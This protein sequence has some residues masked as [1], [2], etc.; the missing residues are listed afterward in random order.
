[1]RVTSSFH[2]VIV[3][4][5]AMLTAFCALY[6]A[7]KPLIVKDGKPNAEIIISGQPTRT[8]KLAAEE[9]QAGI[10]KMTGARLDVT[11]APGEKY[12]VKIYV[13]RSVFTDKQGIDDNG[14]D[15]GAFRVKSGNSWLALVG[16]D[17]DFVP[18]EPWTKAGAPSDPDKIRMMAEWDRRTGSFYGN[19][20]GSLGRRYNGALEM[21][22]DDECGSLNA[23]YAFLGR[24]G[25]RW[26]MAGELGEIMP[27]LSDIPLPAVDE[28][29]RPAFGLRCIF[30][31][32][33]TVFSLKRDDMLWRLRLGLNASSR[34]LGPASYHAHGLNNVLLR[35]EMRAAHPEYYAMLAGGARRTNTNHACLSS[36]GLA[37]EA[38]R[39]AR[40]AF[41]VY[42]VP[43]VSLMPEDGFTFCKCDLCK[44]KEMPEHGR[45]GEHS[46]YVWG[47]VDRVAR[48]VAKTH[49]DRTISCAAY[50]T[51]VLPPRNIQKL[52][53][54]VQVCIVHGRGWLFPDASGYNPVE[55][56]RAWQAKTDRP[57][58]GYEHYPLTHRGHEIP[59]YF[60]RA[61]AAGLRAHAGSSHGEFVEIGWGPADVRGHGLHSPEFAHLKVYVTARLYWDPDLNLDALLEE[62]YRLFYGPAA[63]EMKR[64]IEYAEANWP[65]MKK[66]AKRIEK[67]QELFAAARKKAEP[68]SVYDRR[69][70]PLAEFL[71]PMEALRERLSRGREGTPAGKGLARPGAQIKVDGRLDEAAWKDAPVIKLRE[72]RSGKDPAVPTEFRVIWD[73][74]E[75]SGLLC[76]GIRCSE[77]DMAGLKITGVRDGDDAMWHGD[78]VE[79]M[80]ETQCHSYY[81]LTVDPLGRVYDIDFEGGRNFEW[82]AK[83]RV[84]TFRGPDF[85]SAEICLPV[86]GEEKPGDPLHELAGWKPTSKEPWHI[87]VC[88]GRVRGDK[89]EQSAWSPVGEKGGWHNWLKFGKFSVE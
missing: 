38:A 25:A 3:A 57:L 73:G 32:S 51:Y 17:D 59:Y 63:A 41:D 27:E 29:V 9:L 2:V 70:A 88:R 24:L 62:H 86:T 79:L 89:Q 18:R 30:P 43:S 4:V 40:A 76:F 84:A 19:P 71:A 37:Q 77:P 55:L 22:A 80:L 15:D 74:K 85:W 16:R 78:T 46:D 36:E 8:Q 58:M 26:Y 21:W 69:I 87:N 11:N 33:D 44:G 28:T 75:K 13:G 52:A 54:N 10:E 7:E 48:E 67:A 5:A 81:H 34:A 20:W 14:L 83:A 35:P 68:G 31:M 6:A 65:G 49:P 82:S 39:Y 1:M 42:D 23:V 50:N 66:D 72:L 61:I 53:P 45:L 12:P 64:F 47:F 60:P 56:R